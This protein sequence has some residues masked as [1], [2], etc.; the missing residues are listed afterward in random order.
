M[1]VIVSMYCRSYRA[2]WT[3]WR[4]L[5]QEKNPSKEHGAGWGLRNAAASAWDA[6]GE[7][8]PDVEDGR[9]G[10]AEGSTGPGRPPRAPGVAATANAASAASPQGYRQVG[11]FRNAAA[12]PP[13]GSPPATPPRGAATPRSAATPPRPGAPTTPRTPAT[14]PRGSP[15]A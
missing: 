7:A 1:I 5:A 2:A 3:S 10:A 15:S 11:S 14:P 9:S 8:G 13:R 6:E 4:H 12:T